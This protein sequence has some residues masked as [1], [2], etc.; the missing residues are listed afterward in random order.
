MHK[1]NTKRT[2]LLNNK[3]YSSGPIVYWMSRDQRTKDNWALIFA[4]EQA[5]EKKVPLLVIFSLYPKYKNI[6]LRQI[7]FMF[8]GLQ[9]VEKNLKKLNIPFILL[10][11]KTEQII[12]DFVKKEKIGMIVTDFSPLLPSRKRKEKIA[13]QISIPFYEVDT[14]NIVP[15]W[16]ASPKQ[17]FG[18]YTI[19]PKVNKLLSEFLE[20]FILLKKHPYTYEKSFKEVIW[21]KELKTLN[22]DSSVKPLDIPSGEN[23]AIKAMHNFLTKRLD[24]YDEKRNDPTE[25]GQSNLSYY[26]HFGQLSSQRVALEMGELA[27]DRKDK[28]AY[29]EELIVR[30]ELSDNYCFY[31]KNYKSIKGLPNW[32]LKT[33]DEHKDDK[34][35]ITYTLDQLEKAQTHDE[36][37]NASQLE[38]VHKGKIHGYMRMYW[39]KKILEWTKSTQQA[40]D[41]CVYINDKYELDGRDPNGYVG[42]LWSVGG[43]HD[44]AWF[45]RPIFGKI[46]YMSYNGAKSKFNIKKYIA[47]NQF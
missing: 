12:C 16:I 1:V 44:R 17:E 35:E 3:S 37:W 6:N 47:Q 39:A 30:K 22:P 38:V 41:F 25:N 32:A 10:T 26:L 18:A 23:N 20:E 5:L 13:N 29:L 33:I 34:R 24:N 14:H 45:D 43:L 36:L 15:V 27:I 28:D 46:R 7:D 31:N 2:I 8:K 40:I 19:R 4:Q 9:V 42:I 11:G 21:E